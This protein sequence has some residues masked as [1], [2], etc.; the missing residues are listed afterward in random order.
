MRPAALLAHL[1]E[2]G[3]ILSARGDR[4]RVEAPRGVLTPDIRA[5]LAEHKAD[6]VP[7]LWYQEALRRWWALTAQ[8][9]D[10]APAAIAET[11]Q[12]IVRLMD[13]VGGPTATRLRRSW[14]REWWQETGVCPYCGERGPFHDPE[15]GGEAA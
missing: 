1:R 5:A 7:L 10:A 2:R 15:R 8:G 9:A 14:G 3:V 12:T 11:Y 13:E 4:L 6:V